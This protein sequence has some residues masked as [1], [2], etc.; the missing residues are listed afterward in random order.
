MTRSVLVVGAGIA[1]PVVAFWLA[2]AGVAVTVV[3]RA[4]SP[5]RSGGHA[6][7]V[8]GAAAEVVDRMDLLPAVMARRVERDRIVFHE[9]RGTVEMSRISSVLHERHVEIQRDSFI[10]VLHAATRSDVDYRWGVSIETLHQDDDAVE[11]TLTDGT[12]LTVD[13]VIGADGL[14]SRVRHLALGPEQRFRRDLGAALAVFSFPNPGIP[15]RHVHAVA[16]VDVG[17]F[18]YPVADGAA[19]ALLLFRDPAVATTHHRDRAAQVALVSRVADRVGERLPLSAALVSAADDLY[20]DV[21]AQ[22]RSDRW[23][24]GRVGLVGDAAWSPGPAVGGGTS[25]A[26][27]GAFVLAQHLAAGE[28]VAPSLAA[29]RPVLLGATDRARRAAPTTLRQLVPTSRAA[30]WSTPRVLR[31]VA[32]LP[33]RLGRALAVAGED[34]SALPATVAN[35]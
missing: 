23:S 17:A 16:D 6:V 22:I 25:L 2:R 26:V 28:E 3:D 1:G 30:A 8:A 21:I 11:V 12:A 27:L 13:A 20:V 5:R 24:V 34:R 33:P 35:R 7:D 19:R 14:H 31:A 18:T 9:R 32:G 10:E 4:A 15:D 29:V